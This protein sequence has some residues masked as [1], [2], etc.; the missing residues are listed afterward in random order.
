VFG[1]GQGLAG[2]FNE[3]ITAYAISRMEEMRIAPGDRTVLAM[4]EHVTQRL[5]GAGQPVQRFY[6]LP[7]SLP[8]IGRLAQEVLIHTEELR[9]QRDIE[10]IILFYHK[11][12]TSSRYRPYMLPLLPLNQ[13]WLDNLQARP[14]PG[15]VLPTLSM[16]WEQLFE[17]LIRQDLYVSLNKAFVESL[18]SENASRLMAM[19][20]AERNI[21]DRLEELT[22]RF[23]RQRQ[24]NITDELLDI[25]GGFE[26]MTGG[27]QQFGRP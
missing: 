20:A 27:R 13:Q 8:G 23:N 25:V 2:Q 26:A 3:Q 4:G 18:A 10:Q 7:G 15:K 16:D 24:D 19:Q 9:L 21:E 6:D 5:T 12:I 1:S 17:S 11:P 22:A 14:W